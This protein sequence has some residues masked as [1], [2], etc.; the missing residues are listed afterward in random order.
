[1]P[2]LPV[3]LSL[4]NRP[5]DLGAIVLERQLELRGGSVALLD[6][7]L[8]VGGSGSRLALGLRE[9]AVCRS[10][11]GR[12]LRGPLLLLAALAQSLLE[13]LRVAASPCAVC[14][15]RL[16]GDE[17]NRRSGTRPTDNDV[18]DARPLAVGDDRRRLKPTVAEKLG[19]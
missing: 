11:I 7:A 10:P 8:K 15:Q 2:A 19:D 3:K 13:R 4:G 12:G 16:G 18:S 6:G 5:L 1:M 14:R 9:G 17:L